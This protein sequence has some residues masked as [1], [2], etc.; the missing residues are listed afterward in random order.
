M[1]SGWQDVHG[2]FEAVLS[3]WAWLPQPDP[4]GEF[5]KIYAGVPDRKAV[6]VI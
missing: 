2:R 6:E 4:D 5:R 1:G 3:I